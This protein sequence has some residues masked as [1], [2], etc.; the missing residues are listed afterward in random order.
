MKDPPSLFTSNRVS[1]DWKSS[2][3][4]DG[5]ASKTPGIKKGL[6]EQMRQF[7][8]KPWL[9]DTGWCAANWAKHAFTL[10][11]DYLILY[12]LNCFTPGMQNSG[13]FL[14]SLHLNVN[15]ITSK[16]FYESTAVPLC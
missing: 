15:T 5:A 10:S 14:K 12:N 1:N 7:N 13:F 9:K 6:L 2:V 3:G 4:E 16:P 11:W 8:N